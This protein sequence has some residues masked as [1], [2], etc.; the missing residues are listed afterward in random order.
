MDSDEATALLLK[1]SNADENDQSS[2]SGAQHVV[3]LLGSIPLAII[4]AGAA[5]REL[6]T[7]EEYCEAFTDRRKDLLE[8]WNLPIGADYKYTVYA[9]WEVSVNAIRKTAKG[10]AGVSK[11][12]SVDAANA[13]DLLNMF[14]FWYN[15]DISEEVLQEVWASVPNFDGDQWWTS[16]MIQL[17]RKDRRPKWDP[18]PFRKA[19]NMLSK[20]SL[21]YREG[22]RVSLHPLVQSCIQDL[23][24]DK[25][26]L[27]WWTK[28]L[29][30]LAMAVRTEHAGFREANR[31]QM[32]LGPHLDTCL[33]IRD[34]GD[35]LVEEDSPGKRM[36]AILRLLN[37]DVWRGEVFSDRLLLAQRAVEYGKKMLDENDRQ[38]WICLG[39]S[40]KLATSA[41]QWQTA[42]LLL[43]AKVITYLNAHPPNSKY[44]IYFLA[45]L[46]R[47][48]D[49][50]I[51]G[52]KMQEALEI[53]E[54]V[55]KI[56]KELQ[57]E[58]VQILRIEEAL[59]PIYFASGRKDY[60]LDVAQTTYSKVEASLG[61]ASPEALCSK[62]S[63]AD[64]YNCTGHPEKTVEMCHQVRI[65]PQ[66][67]PYV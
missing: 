65:S 40:A 58:R 48:I 64:V 33:K 7:H 25:T 53:G 30:M 26:Q 16:H 3:Q 5:I 47:L 66:H 19:I 23:L 62:Y 34:F 14:G 10:E 12:D 59:V 17:F 9:T 15:E 1:A 51:E 27:Q 29:I 60:A 39:Y 28:S 32:L 41:G 45:A 44:P 63:L 11:R 37:Y 8:S 46:E 24:D 43:E 52:D 21:V 56:C 18:L 2:R 36:R 67:H 42:L 4:N 50:C 57:D 54:K 49:A 31:R 20:Y 38:L 55:L 13:L 6:Y 35:F 61:E 22:G